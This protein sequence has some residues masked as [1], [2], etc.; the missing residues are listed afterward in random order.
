ML[1]I[2]LLYYISTS[3]IQYILLFYNIW[4]FV[5]N[6]Y[7]IFIILYYYRNIMTINKLDPEA[8]LIKKPLH[9][10]YTASLLE[11]LK[12]WEEVS[13]E[14]DSGRFVFYKN[15]KKWFWVHYNSAWIDFVHNPMS[16][17]AMADVLHPILSHADTFE[18][19]IPNDLLLRLKDIFFDSKKKKEWTPFTIEDLFRNINL[20][21]V[22]STLAFEKKLL[23]E[24]EHK[25]AGW[26][27]KYLEYTTKILHELYTLYPENSVIKNK[28][29]EKLH[30]LE[31]YKKTF[32]DGN[33]IAWIK[34]NISDLETFLDILEGQDG[35]WKLSNQIK[36][37]RAWNNTHDFSL[38][39][40]WFFNKIYAWD[41]FAIPYAQFSNASFTWWLDQW[42]KNF[43]ELNGWDKWSEEINRLWKQQ[44]SLMDDTLSF[45]QKNEIFQ[46]VNQE[47]I[48]S[49]WFLLGTWS[50]TLPGDKEYYEKIHQQ[51][52]IDDFVSMPCSDRYPAVLQKTIVSFYLKDLYDE[53]CGIVGEKSLD[54]SISKYIYELK[55]PSWFAKL[56]SSFANKEKKIESLKKIEEK[57][58]LLKKKF[59]DVEQQIKK[60]E[61][62]RKDELTKM[63]SEFSIIEDFFT[64]NNTNI[65]TPFTLSDQDKYLYFMRN[66]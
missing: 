1:I 53:V 13:L 61:H 52:T 28:I 56:T 23:Q 16:Q 8:S 64:V 55:N 25:I 42:T 6:V 29:G 58:W 10:L 48:N 4:Q 35:Q 22:L 17:E 49:I 21:N 46:R 50:N 40:D 20:E 27:E 9:D 36:E 19:K 41:A 43:G 63:A 24:T 59:T 2:F 3:N 62:K 32:S 14:W 7:N 26:L 5:L 51:I 11:T 45:V 39:I 57:I 65:Y 66:N 60:F 44:E 30:Y 37:L 33:F 31:S 38:E 18:G 12:P 15:D 47:Y 34:N 54:K